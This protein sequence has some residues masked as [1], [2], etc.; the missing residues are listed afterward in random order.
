MMPQNMYFELELRLN[1]VAWQY[2]AIACLL[3]FLLVAPL[4]LP[5]FLVEH[6]LSKLSNSE[7][8]R[9]AQHCVAH[10]NGIK[11]GNLDSNGYS[12]LFFFL[13]LLLF[14]CFFFLFTF[15]FRTTRT[16]SDVW[17]GK[18]YPPTLQKLAEKYKVDKKVE[19]NIFMIFSYDLICRS[20]ENAA[21]RT[22]SERRIAAKGPAG[23]PLICETDT[24]WT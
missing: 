4:L 21:P 16:M 7:W 6:D 22:Q 15:L 1:L 18:G 23:I 12:N 8:E 17:I 3:P 13:L 2:F 19:S 20:A 10:G 24:R 11:D 9:I 14:Y 5:S